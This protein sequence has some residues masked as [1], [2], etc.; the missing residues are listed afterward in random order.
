MVGLSFPGVYLFR[1]TVY[2]KM[3]VLLPL[4]AFTICTH[5][6]ELRYNGRFGALGFRLS[7]K[8]INLSVSG[9]LPAITISNL[10]FGTNIYKPFR[11]LL[12]N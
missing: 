7:L 4:L 5:F 9:N 2:L 12:E 1:V 3:N 8:F 6:S 10:F 11:E